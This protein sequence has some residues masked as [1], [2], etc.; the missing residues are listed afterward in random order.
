MEATLQSIFR[1]GFDAY[2]A[3]HG[4]SMQRPVSGLVFC[5][6][7]VEAREARCQVAHCTFDVF[8]DMFLDNEVFD[9][10]APELYIYR[11][12]RDLMNCCA[13]QVFSPM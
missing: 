2:Q 9:Y 5:A 7:R 1:A 3:A 11:F 6:F 13:R 8:E 12:A 4:L 10:G